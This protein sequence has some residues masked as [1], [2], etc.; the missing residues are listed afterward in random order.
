VIRSTFALKTI[1]KLLIQV[2]L[3]F[4]SE[5]IFSKKFNLNIYKVIEKIKGSINCALEK[6]YKDK[7]I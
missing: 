7:D 5:S 1:N 6:I 3:F 4:F 2:S